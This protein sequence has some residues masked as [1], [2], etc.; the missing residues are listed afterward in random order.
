M[1]EAQ[2]YLFLVASS[3]LP[4]V[5]G[6]SEWLARQAAAALPAGAVQRW[7]HL[8]SLSVPAFDDLRHE[9][10]GQYPAP[11]ADLAELLAATLEATDLVLVAPVYWYSLPAA[12]KL[13]LDH[14]SAWLRVPGLDFKPRMAGKRL[15]LISTSGDRTKAQPMVD[16]V[17]LCAE[18]MAMR[19]QGVLWG[20][21]GMPRAVQQDAE[22]IAAAAHF[23]AG[24]K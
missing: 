14:W 21:G 3:R 8:R 20:K 9:G 2:N 5:Q 15:W 7:E 1:A 23:F 17:R 24:A 4:G 10:S 13:Y 18:F 22:A 16:S 19:W 6:N 12:L 11:Q